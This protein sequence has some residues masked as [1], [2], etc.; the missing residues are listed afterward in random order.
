MTTSVPVLDLPMVLSLVLV[1][2]AVALLV[3]ERVSMEM[4]A[5]GTLSVMLVL[6]HVVPVTDA[7]G[8]NQLDAAR[9]LAG[10]ANPALLTVLALLV[11]GEGLIQTGALERMARRL[12]PAR[13]RPTLALG[14]TL[15]V[16]A[17]IS[18]VLNNTPVVVIFIPILQSLGQRF[19]RVPSQIMI[20][21]S[22]AAI[23]GGMTTLIGS[24][25]NLLV[26]SALRDLG[27]PGFHFFEF[28]LP[29][30][31]MAVAGLAYTLT[32]LPRFLP[33]Y[34]TA[35]GRL[36]GGSRQFVAQLEIPAESG[37]VG[38]RARAGQFP[39]LPDVTVR[40][41]QRGE[42]TELPPFADAAIRAG[43]ILL[44][45]ATRDALTRARKEHPG[46]FRT[47]ADSRA[48]PVEAADGKEVAG[49]TVAE[50]PGEQVLVE[51]MIPPASRL[52]G[53]TLRLVGFHQRYGCVVLGIQRRARMYMDRLADIRLEGGDVVLLQGTRRQ[54]AAFHRPPHDLVLISGSS[55]AMPRRG[56]GRRAALVF[57]LMLV[58]MVTGLVPVV[59][60]ALAGATGMLLVGALN[61]RQATRALDRRIVLLV[62]TALALGEALQATGGAAW[63]AHSLLSLLTGAG[64]AVILSAYFLLVAV[65]TNL[66]TNNATAVLFAP[67]GLALGAQ[68]GVDPRV[69]AVATV[70]AAN[71][72]FA[73]PMGY[74]TNLLVMA[75]GGYRFAD[76]VR[77]GAPLMFLCWLVFSLMAP[78]L[79]GL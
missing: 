59:T 52:V 22:Y 16:V 32:V 45:A 65:L 31:I 27:H 39:M 58:A 61:V 48:S 33:C 2:G 14:F 36:P 34:D 8:V 70:L 66:L 75:P 25:T 3:T 29:G 62:A 79:Y 6:F 26:S 64:P 40:A 35:A 63:L 30:V 12:T 78:L 49:D 15:G 73:S 41:I 21:L 7:A 53:Q 56:P 46:L 17:G 9:L 77:A 4:A 50:A 43:D 19:G 47:P 23:L 42:H 68:V 54:V 24:S 76:Y 10:F 20:P 44:V 5:L 74:Q 13:A 67:V 55:T 57:T 37:L 60:A 69:F 51:A 38:T 1:T 71:C 11:V 28:T 72:S 18:G